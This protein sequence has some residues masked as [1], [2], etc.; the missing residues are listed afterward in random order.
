MLG[1]LLK[2]EQLRAAKPR[3]VF[4]SATDPK[5]LHD[6]P[7]GVERHTHIGRMSHAGGV[8]DLLHDSMGA[9]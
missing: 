1:D 9:Y 5:G 4:A 7:E 8:R 3:K 2:R 6:V